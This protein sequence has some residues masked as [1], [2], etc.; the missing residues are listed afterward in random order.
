MRCPRKYLEE[1]RVAGV[2]KAERVKSW[3]RSI[4]QSEKKIQKLSSDGMVT[5][6]WCLRKDRAMHFLN[7]GAWY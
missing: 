7:F 1:T 2:E 5:G 6:M 3:W 4:N